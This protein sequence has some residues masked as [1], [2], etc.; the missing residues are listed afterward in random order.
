MWLESICQP[1]YAKLW[2]NY[3]YHEYHLDQLAVS[4]LSSSGLEK[5]VFSWE[6][7]NFPTIYV[8]LWPKRQNSLLILRFPSKHQHFPPPPISLSPYYPPPP[9][10]VITALEISRTPCSN[11]TCQ[12][13]DMH[14]YTIEVRMCQP[15]LWHVNN[16]LTSCLYGVIIALD[17]IIIIQEGRFRQIVKWYA[18][19]CQFYCLKS[20]HPF[21]D[22]VSFLN[23]WNLVTNWSYFVSFKLNLTSAKM[24]ELI[25]LSCFARI[26]DWL[27]PQFI[28]SCACASF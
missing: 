14:Y 22:L 18:S 11:P 5:N 25:W 2:I 3:H 8:F 20:S 27:P 6:L 13:G 19:L 24:Y 16:W 28:C 23:C 17:F 4:H 1:Q 15:N 9:S 7:F 12:A 10:P 21:S 26:Q